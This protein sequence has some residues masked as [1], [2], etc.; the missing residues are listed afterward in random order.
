M[1]TILLFFLAASAAWGQS[2]YSGTW[3]ESGSATWSANSG[4][5]DTNVYVAPAAQGGSDSNPCTLTQP[6]L[7][8]QRASTVV[9]G[10]S[11][12]SHLVMFRGGNYFLS[13]PWTLNSG[14]SG[15]A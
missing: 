12:G 2:V 7:T 11:G 4:S 3:T 13:A 1:K 5:T 14:D 9:R 15:T 10:M 8:P 6:C